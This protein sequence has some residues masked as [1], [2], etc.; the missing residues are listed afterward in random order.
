[1]TNRFIYSLMNTYRVDFTDK[2]Q[3]G[4]EYCYI[5]IYTG[6]LLHRVLLY[7]YVNFLQV[8]KMKTYLLKLFDGSNPE[9]YNVRDKR[10]N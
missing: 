4:K 7:Q 9:G 10:S 8:Q 5:I 6:L 3:D 1:M 2:F